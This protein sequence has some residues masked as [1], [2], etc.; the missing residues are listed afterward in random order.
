MTLED[1]L[2]EKES[3]TAEVPTNVT[4]INTKTGTAKSMQRADANASLSDFIDMV[5]L[6]VEYVMSDMKVKFMPD[7]NRKNFL[8]PDVPFNDPVVT[9]KIKSRRPK[10]E[11]KPIPRED[12]EE[13]Y[14]GEQRLG[15]IYGQRFDC[16]VQFNIF[17]S[18][19]TLANK[20]MDKFEELMI[21]YAGYI[22]KQGVVDM[23]F[24][25]QY[26]DSEY[27]NFRET[28]S[29]RNLEYYVEIEK[30]TVIFNEKINEVRIFGDAKQN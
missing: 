26:T 29:V 20:V 3:L 27:N 12:M 25:E 30:L 24:T 15:T 11:L 4:P 10:N 6:I 1:L 16:K 21:A 8:E 19:Y 14:N 28:L 18:E 13:E 7:E 23:Y 5:G 22:K 9:Y 2:N 17:A